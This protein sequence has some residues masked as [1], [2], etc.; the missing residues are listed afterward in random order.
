MVGNSTTRHLVVPVKSAFVIDCVIGSNFSPLSD[1]CPLPC[2]S[3]M[4]D[5]MTCLSQK[6][7]VEVTVAAPSLGLKN[8]VC[9]S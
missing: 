2:N 7:E 8:L 1:L 5:H 6:N 4:F 9:F 3:A